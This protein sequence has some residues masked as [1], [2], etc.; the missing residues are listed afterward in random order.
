MSCDKEEQGRIIDYRKR[1]DA[2]KEYTTPTRL[3]IDELYSAVKHYEKK[4]GVTIYLTT[5]GDTPAEKE[6]VKSVSQEGNI[7][8]RSLRGGY[9]G[10]L[11]LRLQQGMKKQAIGYIMAEPT[12]RDSVTW[13]ENTL[14]QSLLLKM[15]ESLSRYLGITNKNV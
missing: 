11:A 15:A 12:K 9:I 4:Y 2:L 1:M 10:R 5:K 14:N 13:G 8:L 3:N 7:A 6:I